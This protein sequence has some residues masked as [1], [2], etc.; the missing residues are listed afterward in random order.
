MLLL[1]KQQ[2]VLFV[3]CLIFGLWHIA[4]QWTTTLL[5]FLQWDTTEVMTIVDLG[6][7][8][9]FGSVCNA[10]GALAFGQMADTAG[11]KA[12]FMLSCIFTSIYYSGIS[13]AK[14]WYGFFFL[15]LL[16]FGYQMDGTAEM[17]LA[18]ITTERERTGALMRLTVPQAIAMFFGPILG[19]KIAAYTTLRTSQFICGVTL[20]FTLMPV[21][22]F[23]LP[24]THSIPRLATARLRPQDYWPMITKN[25]ALKEGLILRG[26]IVSSYVC[27]EMIWRNFLLRSF[28]KDTNDSAIILLVMAGSLLGVQFIV[29]PFLQ[30]RTSPR[31]LLQISMIGLILCYYMASLTTSFEQVLIITAVHTGAYAAAYAESCTQITSAVEITDLGKATGLA[32]MTQWASHFLLPIYASHIVEHYHFTYAFYTSTILSTVAFAYITIFAKNTN[33]RLGTPLPSLVATY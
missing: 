28:M 6:Y 14:S 8:Q 18:T 31:R 24:T 33:N 30:R 20:L 11:A 7:I 29:L 1:E 9:A 23:L 22:A 2:R 25:T 12:M 21:L 4:T 10:I 15:Q 27:Y 32:S 19:S 3:L 13:I 17:Y 5:S 16:R 26:L